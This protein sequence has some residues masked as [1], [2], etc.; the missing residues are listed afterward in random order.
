M[1]YLKYCKLYINIKGILRVNKRGIF[2]YCIV[3]MY[4]KIKGEYQ[5]FY[6]YKK[7]IQS[8]IEGV[9]EGFVFIRGVHGVVYIH[10]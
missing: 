9:L 6:I 3:Y 5:E 2:E 1:E 4:I 10:I 8:M 7:G